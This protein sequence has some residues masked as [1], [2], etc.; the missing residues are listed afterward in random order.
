MRFTNMLGL[1]LLFYG[2]KFL[3][4][5]YSRD[6]TYMAILSKVLSGRMDLSSW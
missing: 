3:K 2:L 5:W 6:K 4:N 1:N